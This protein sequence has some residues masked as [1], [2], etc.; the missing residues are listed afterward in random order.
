MSSALE[1]T[2]DSTPRANGSRITRIIDYYKK[3]FNNW[4][5]SNRPILCV[6]SLASW[7]YLFTTGLA[8]NSQVYIMKVNENGSATSYFDIWTLILIGKVALTNATTN[9]FILCVLSALIGASCSGIPSPR[10]KA[11]GS[12]ELENRYTSA[13]TGAF[14]IYCVLISGAV[15]VL[16]FRFTPPKPGSANVDFEISEAQAKYKTLATF[17]SFLCLIEGYSP[18]AI[19]FAM[20]Y[21]RPTPKEP[22]QRT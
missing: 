7:F 22:P 12:S 8:V 9:V 11:E 16:D 6:L 1:Q 3:R 4:I 20:K 18:F 5:G 2:G 21:I 14:L 15:G 10:P 13:A 17:A 19:G